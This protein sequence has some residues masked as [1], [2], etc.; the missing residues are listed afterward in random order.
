MSKLRQDMHASL[1]LKIGLDK[2]VMA[3]WIDVRNE[4]WLVLVGDIEVAQYGPLDRIPVPLKKVSFLNINF[5][6]DESFCNLGVGYP[7]FFI[8]IE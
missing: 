6:R 8:Y 1:E 2:L 4:L 7:K 3:H 5:Y